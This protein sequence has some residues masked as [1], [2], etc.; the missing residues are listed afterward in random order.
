LE[1]FM[2]FIS[3]INKIRDCHQNAVVTIGNFDGVHLGHQRLMGALNQKARALSKPSMV[4]TFEPLPSEY[5][6]PEKSLARLTPLREKLLLFEKL[7]IDYV[8]CLK[9]NRKLVNCSAEKFINEILIERIKVSHLIVGEDFRFGKDRKGDV[10]LLRKASQKNGFTL[11][12][13]QKMTEEGE[14][15]SSTRIR[16]ALHASNF[17]LAKR[18]LG[19]DYTIQGR[20]VHGEKRGRTLGF[21][22]ANVGLQRI[23]PPLSGVFAVQV[24]GLGEIPVLGVANIGQRP[25]LQGSKKLLEVHLFDFNACIYDRQ[26][27]VMPLK[28]LRDEKK[29]PSVAALSAQIAEDVILAKQ[30]FS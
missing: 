18:L 10:A 26:I 21:P 3:S 13:M 16:T 20:V 22:T 12:I 23:K 11:E 1:F 7:Q 4:I 25:T 8:L 2:Q 6:S 29:F 24:F 15:I 27:V 5:F 17:D 19:R 9:F 28:K 14:R 30:F